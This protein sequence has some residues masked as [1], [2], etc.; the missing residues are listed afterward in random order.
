MMSTPS[1]QSRVEE[2]L[3]DRRRLGFSL[4]T[5]GSYLMSF[6]RYIDRIGHSGPLSSEMILGWA[7][8]DTACTTP[9]TWAKRLLNIRRFLNYCAQT[10]GETDVPDS[11][12]FGRPR[13]RPTPHIY[14]ETEIADLLAAAK[15]LPVPGTLRP[16]TYETFFGLLAATGMRLS[17]A[18][19]LR[20]A[21]VDL[22][23]NHVTVRQAKWGKSRLVPLHP[24][25]CDAMSRYLAL[26][27]RVPS[28]PDG[29]FFVSPSGTAIAR[30][31]AQNVFERLRADLGGSRAVAV[32]RRGSMTCGTHLFADG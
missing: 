28:A 12:V 5:T 14:T 8:S 7:Q 18:L 10:D 15:R 1:M 32:R 30:K 4:K 11:N 2:Y 19:H 17:E 26:R 23:A 22:I 9:A 13:G 6:A 16:A 24:T 20:C 31:T 3:D 27:Q 29:H 21:D 25:V